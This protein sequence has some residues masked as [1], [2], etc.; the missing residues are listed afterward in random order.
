LSALPP[1]PDASG[2]RHRAR[3]V[4]CRLALL[5]A[6]LLGSAVQSRA[7]DVEGGTALHRASFQ[8]TDAPIANPER[9]FYA[10][11]DLTTVSSQEVE[12]HVRAGRTLMRA[13]VRLDAYRTADLPDELLRRL[14][15]GFDAMR[16]GGG[17]AIPRFTYNFPG[18]LRNPA[19]TADARIEQVLRHITQ[20]TPLLQSHADVI[21]FLEAGFI[22]A[23]GEWHTSPSGLDSPAN[24]R[25]I[26]DALLAALPAERSV[27]FRY[28]ADLLTWYGVGSAAT[29]AAPGSARARSG[30]HNDCFLSTRTDAG[31]Y[32]LHLPGLRGFAREL[33]L[34]VPFGGETCDIAP[35]RG[36]CEDILREGREYA[37]TYLNDG[38]YRPSFHERWIAG[39]C[40]AEVERSLGYRLRLEGLTVPIE[41]R[42]GQPLPVRVT[43]RNEGWA[44]VSNPRAVALRL[45]EPGK[46]RF[47][48]VALPSADAR[49]W[50]PLAKADPSSA[51]VTTAIVPI[52]V[53]PG[54]YMLALALPDP[55]PRLAADPR[56]AIRPAN[57]DDPA[58]G[59]RWNAVAGHFTTGLRI[60]VLP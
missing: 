51:L 25:R 15:A 19:H 54:D 16:G 17:K 27:L 12:R 28:P 23:W 50:R 55:N 2:R 1:H 21:A 45:I 37:V 39:G 40:M 6:A 53:P 26:R 34:H 18:D 9:G 60:R 36:S 49:L 8:P 47:H 20:L 4:A 56:Y 33:V 30:I 35:A 59:Q 57:R 10:D 42:R 43:L 46:D 41:V 5:T 3:A 44:P 14:G 48:T 7:Q 31:T 29:P 24:K 58:S 11:V 32:P 13:Y 38:Y 22:G 52:G